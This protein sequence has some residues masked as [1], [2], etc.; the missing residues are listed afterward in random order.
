MIFRQFDQTFSTFF[1][2]ERKTIYIEL[3]I[4]DFDPHQHT[5]TMTQ[6]PFSGTANINIF[7]RKK[8]FTDLF[9]EASAKEIFF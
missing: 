5:R 7:S 3:S 4:V 6:V 9:F 8:T 2:I 1:S